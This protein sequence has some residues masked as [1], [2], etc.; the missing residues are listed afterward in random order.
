MVIHFMCQTKVNK[1]NITQSVQTESHKRLYEQSKRLRLENF[2]W[3]LK[4]KSHIAHKFFF[5]KL[6]LV[7]LN[8]VEYLNEII[9]C[10]MFETAP[11][12]YTRAVRVYIIC[13]CCNTRDIW[14]PCKINCTT[15]TN[16]LYGLQNL[17]LS[18]ADLPFLQI[19]HEFWH[20]Y[21]VQKYKIAYSN[22]VLWWHHFCSVVDSHKEFKICLGILR[23]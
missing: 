9:V 19:C 8:T 3:L 18:V 1:I 12:M 21:F 4:L 5:Y 15:F 7:K 20:C 6:L 16:K 22:F 10:V 13:T 23:V 17:T 11:R 2:L 14:L